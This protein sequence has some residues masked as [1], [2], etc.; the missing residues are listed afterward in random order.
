MRTKYEQ[1][2][3]TVVQ[4]ARDSDWLRG[5]SRWYPASESTPTYLEGEENPGENWE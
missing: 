4:A 5:E 1:P 2:D 3:G